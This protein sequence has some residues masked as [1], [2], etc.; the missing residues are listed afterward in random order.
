MGNWLALDL[1]LEY[2]GSSRS[3][4]GESAADRPL[5]LQVTLYVLDFAASSSSSN[6]DHPAAAGSGAALAGPN[7]WNLTG[8]SSSSGGV[9]TSAAAGA[10]GSSSSVQHLIDPGV[11]VAGCYSG[12]QM[13]VRSG[14]KAVHKLR[15]LLVQ[16]GL[17]QFGVADVMLMGGGISEKAAAA[18]GAG[19]SSSKLGAEKSSRV[20]FSQERMFVLVTGE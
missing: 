18:E 14:T 6:S 15:A 17:Y 12:I 2:N 1:E 3:S 8:R 5:L 13:Q 7:S 20:Y 4:S 10:S 9:T 19:S 11:F 16:P